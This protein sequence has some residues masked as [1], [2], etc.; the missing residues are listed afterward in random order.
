MPIGSTITL[1]SLPCG[2]RSARPGRTG[3]HP[4]ELATPWGNP[5]YDWEAMAAEGYA[6][7]IARFKHLLE[8]VDLVRIDHFRGFE[9]AWEVP[10]QATTAIHGEWVRGPGEAVFT[11][12]GNALGGGQPPVV[13]EDLGLIT[14]EVRALLKATRFPGMK[15][16]Q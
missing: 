8:L 10:A 9:A 13:A 14:D 16:L 4:L 3:T 12:I 7:W 5:L 2:T 6:W 1:C 15:V 11:A